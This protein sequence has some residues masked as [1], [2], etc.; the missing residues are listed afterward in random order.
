MTDQ[1]KFS[2]EAFFFGRKK[3]IGR[4][5]HVSIPKLGLFNVSAK[6]DTGAYRGAI[7][8][9]EISVKKDNGKKILEFKVLDSEHPEYKD[10]FHR[11]TK[12]KKMR[13]KNTQSEA[14]DRFVIPIA[15]NIAGEEVRTEL[16]LS[17]RSDMRYP[18][19]IGR[20][21]LRKFIVD[22]NKE[23]TL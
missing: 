18:I 20:R 15:I 19:L 9:S 3:T 21:A 14:Q 5:E 1:K 12:F 8:A 22:V 11:T 13:F 10:V 7:H 2:W 6:I 16:S 17:D 23:Y 4:L